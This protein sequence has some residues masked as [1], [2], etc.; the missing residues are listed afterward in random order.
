MNTR[1]RYDTEVKNIRMEFKITMTNMLRAVIEKVDDIQKQMGN[2]SRVKETLR[3]HQKEMLQI[4]PNATEME[5]A[6]DE[7]ISR[8]DSSKKE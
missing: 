1:P 2:I 4:K 8:P 7:L 6:F 3:K 5:N